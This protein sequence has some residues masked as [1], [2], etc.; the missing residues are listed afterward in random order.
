MKIWKRYIPYLSS[1][2]WHIHTNLTDGKNNILEYCEE[3]IKRKIP[4][5]AF[6]EHVRK[7]LNYDFDN[8]LEEIEIARDKF[9]EL[10]ILS[11]CETKVLSDG[12]LDIDNNLIKKIEYRIFAYHTFPKD[13]KLY[14]I[15]LKKVI[16]NK[17]ICTWAHPGLFLKSNAFEIKKEELVEIFKL[18]K[19]NNVLLEKNKK[20]NLPPES[21]ITEAKKLGVLLVRG[22]DAHSKYEL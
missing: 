11:G 9:P 21:W 13:R 1:G 3:A 10:I 20:Y 17:Y 8:F 5:L 18:M 22:N 12:S 19:K 6:T 4:L 7:E 2:S 14:L 15:T 16:R